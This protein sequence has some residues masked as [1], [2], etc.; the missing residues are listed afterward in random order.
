[1]GYSFAVIK[2]SG[3]IV[4]ESA[5]IG[6]GYQIIMVGVVIQKESVLGSNYII[7]TAVI[8]EHDSKI[9]NRIHTSSGQSLEEALLLVKIALLDLD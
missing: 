3:S 7:G 2:H 8:V 4:D 5:I 6:G 1:M 9:D